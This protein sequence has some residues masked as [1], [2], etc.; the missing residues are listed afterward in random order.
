MTTFL[1]L[2]SVDVGGGQGKPDENA[3]GGGRGKTDFDKVEIGN[4]WSSTG[5]GRGQ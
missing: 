2:R 4:F 3:V 1:I 5:S